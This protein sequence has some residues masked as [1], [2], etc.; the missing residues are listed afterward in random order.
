[1]ECRIIIHLDQYPEKFKVLPPLCDL[2]GIKEESRSAVLSAMWKFIKTVGAQDKDDVT[3]LLPIG[4]LQKVRHALARCPVCRRSLIV[5][6]CDLDYGSERQ[7]PAIAFATRSCQQI[8]HR[9]C[10]GNTQL[11]YQVSDS[12]V[13][14]LTT[15]HLHSTSPTQSGPGEKCPS[16]GL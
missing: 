4:G 14:E 1:M 9:S 13:P 12:S 10:S 15:A 6:L 16:K 8:S 3:K 5:T 2:I 7:R 11:H